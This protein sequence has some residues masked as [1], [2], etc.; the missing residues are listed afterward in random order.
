[1]RPHGKYNSIQKRTP[2]PSAWERS[3]ILSRTSAGNG[4]VK[5]WDVGCPSLHELV[6]HLRQ[7]VALTSSSRTQRPL[8]V[9]LWNIPSPIPEHQNQRWV[10]TWTAFCFLI[11]YDPLLYRS[12][13]FNRFSLSL[14]A[15]CSAVKCAHV[16]WKIIN[17]YSAGQRTPANF[18]FLYA[19]LSFQLQRTSSALP[20]GASSHPWLV[21]YKPAS[22]S[23]SPMTSSHIPVKIPF[24]RKRERRSAAPLRQRRR[25]CTPDAHTRV[26]VLWSPLPVNIPLHTRCSNNTPVLQTLTPHTAAESNFQISRIPRSQM[27]LFSVG[28][29]TPPSVCTH[30]RQGKWGRERER[31]RE[32]WANFA[33]SEV[34][35]TP[36]RRKE[37]TQ[38]LPN[39]SADRS[40]SSLISGER[41][42]R[43]P[44]PQRREGAAETLWWQMKH[45]SLQKKIRGMH[46]KW[47]ERWC[48]EIQE[49]GWHSRVCVGGEG[50]VKG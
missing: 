6:P 39:T 30:W 35:F 47:G 14:R 50:G 4:N 42:D 18:I 22:N 32:R 16:G 43:R 9:K 7:Q 38:R 48:S 37:K 45:A 1:M 31:G 20:T 8:I 3:V 46:G 10:F 49:E 17:P 23:S 15:A 29:M 44:C 36:E 25:W 26:T 2:A 5:N 41:E 34:S 27:K 11:S 19:Q 33:V 40:S 24:S 13:P 21:P 12:Q 28:G